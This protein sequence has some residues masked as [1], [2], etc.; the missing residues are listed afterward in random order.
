MEQDLF[1]TVTPESQGVSSKAVSEFVSALNT[2]DQA[3]SFILLRHGKTIASGAWEPYR[4]D[5][6]HELFSLSKSFVSAA[7]GIAQGE[8]RL[9]I[10]DR[11]IDF[12]P[13]Y[14]TDAVIPAMRRATLR[15]A[16]TM[17]LGH[18]RCSF[19]FVDK[20]HGD[21]VKQI[22]E[23]TPAW[24]PGERF[25]YN[26]GATFMAAAVIHKVTGQNV[27]DYLR[28]R[29]FEPL[30]IKPPQWNCSPTGINIGG[31]GLWLSTQDIA[32]FGHLILN[33]GCWKGKQLIPADYLEEAT[34]F[35]ADNSMNEPPDWKLGYGYQFWRCRHNA[36]RGDGAAGQYALMMPDQDMVFA[37]NSGLG[38]M[39]QVLDQLWDHLLLGIQPDTLPEDP[40]AFR[41]LQDQLNGLAAKRPEWMTS[42]KHFSTGTGKYA[43]ASN[44]YG[45]KELSFDCTED[46][47]TLKI[48][49]TVIPAGFG[50]LVFG[51]APLSAS[52]PKRIASQAAYTD[53]RTLKIYVFCMQTTARYTFELR[54]ED[55]FV[56]VHRTTP[57]A[58]HDGLYDI[59][60]H[61]KKIG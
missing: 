50:K 5:L 27:V 24:E 37:F 60:F 7:I 38:D 45:Y 20:K 22:F 51:D 3:H 21:W 42:A 41:T 57:I 14:L 32:K 46:T 2:L 58:F 44:A 16:L 54:F 1:P 48:D 49:D 6:P 29:L 61:G 19:E 56:S 12:F 33:H 31:W 43:L 30:G 40:E 55:D 35:Q 34:S 18:D 13:E 36:F 8:G 10:H 4:L 26:S 25:T 28:P 47:C 52:M 23:S 15:D 39:Q 59:H 53:E 17:R 9:S 11:L